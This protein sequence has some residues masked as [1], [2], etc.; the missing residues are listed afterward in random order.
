MGLIRAAVITGIVYFVWQFS[1]TYLER[2]QPE[3]RC[4]ISPYI[5]IVLIFLIEMLI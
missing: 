3:L 1:Q 5:P 2:F 4:K